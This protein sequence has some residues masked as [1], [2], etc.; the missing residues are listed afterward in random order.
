MHTAACTV[1]TSQSVPHPLGGGATAE[2]ASPTGSHPQGLLH[3]LG[4][5]TGAGVR[6]CRAMHCTALHCT[7]AQTPSDISRDKNASSTNNEGIILRDVSLG[8]LSVLQQS[9]RVGGTVFTL[10]A[11]SDVDAVID[12]YID[13]GG[14]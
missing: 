1:S 7:L 3:L 9:L 8:P 11:P 13:A 12:L 5:G 6:R 14:Y 10:L 4:G 2:G